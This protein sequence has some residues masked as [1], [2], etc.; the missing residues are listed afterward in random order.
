MAYV[1]VPKDLTRV[2]TKFALNMT[3]R[4]LICFSGA[5]V[6]GIPLYLITRKHLGNDVSALLMVLIMLPL[7]AFALYEKDGMHLEQFIGNYFRVR[8]VYPKKRVYQTENFYRLIQTEIDQRKEVLINAKQKRHKKCR[9][10]K[11]KG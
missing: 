9:N 11:T 2:K 10:N 1:S 6:L 5:A 7:F 3:K 4:Q 8:F